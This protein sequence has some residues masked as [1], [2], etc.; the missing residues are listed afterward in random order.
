[1][2]GESKS[3]SLTL[4]PLIALVV[5]NMVGSGIFL[6][7]ADL[8]R[9]G[10]VSLISWL[11][12]VAGAFLLAYILSNNSHMIRRDGG[13][14]A[15][16]KEGFG[17]F[18]GFQTAYCHWL[19]MWVASAALA[20]ALANY[21]GML[22]PILNNFKLDFW[23]ALLA[24]WVIAVINMRGAHI[25][26]RV[27]VCTVILKLAPIILIIIFGWKY[28]HLNYLAQG[29]QHSIDINLQSVSSAASLTLWAFIGVE[30]ATI[31]YSSLANPERDIPLATL[32]GTAIAS[33]IY[34][35]SSTL[36]M[37]I[38]PKDVLINSMSPFVTTSVLLFG[39]FGKWI[40]V[41]GAAISC[42]G[43]LNGWTFLYGQVAMAAS[44]DGLFPRIFSLRNKFNV[45]AFGIGMTAIL[46]S[47]VL[48][49]ATRDNT[50][51]QFQVI[52]AMASFASLVPYLYSSIT[53]I[54]IMQR[55]KYPFDF[56]NKKRIR[57]FVCAFFAALYSF[58]A[59][60]G[61]GERLI[62]Y[63][64]I[65]LFTSVVLYVLSKGESD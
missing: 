27:Q 56:S 21:L 62:F 5:G 40:M 38:L 24:I 37:G 57:H 30:S 36:I 13:P 11:F 45:P 12:T 51:R 23:I 28:F 4:I 29:L 55:K 61:A 49:L 46:T 22:W 63:G 10:A 52:I 59:L 14:Y 39:N 31:P 64:S 41:L 43:A 47:V 19:S 2:I 58:W 44:K 35:V 25:V 26:G 48:F 6:L 20:I 8:A 15:Y 18:I 34:I 16:A 33:I 65:L 53:N 7:P 9:F 3:K 1:M 50:A 42:L 54:L 60:C 17:N 32:L